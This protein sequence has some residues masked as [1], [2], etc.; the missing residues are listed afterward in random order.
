MKKEIICTVCPR[1][2]RIMVEGENGAIHRV[3]GHS[4]GRGRAY[5]ETEFAAP[6]RTL[7]T[8]VRLLGGQEELLPVRSCA[9]LPRERLLD[10]M[11]VIRTTEVRPPVTMHQV[12]VPD[13]CG[14]GVDIIATKAEC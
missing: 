5:A 11:A 2:C 1:G 8:T 3:E 10:C 12:I 6:V 4:C 13:I 14:S 9:P 7:T